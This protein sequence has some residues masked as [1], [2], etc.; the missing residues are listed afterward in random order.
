MTEMVIN[1]REIQSSIAEIMKLSKPGKSPDIPG[2][3]T[4]SYVW[5]HDK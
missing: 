2:N 4:R 5:G 3:V 1:I